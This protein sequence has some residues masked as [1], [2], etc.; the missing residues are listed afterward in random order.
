MINLENVNTWLVTGC[1]GFIGSNLIEY[2]LLQ[3]QKVV[4][5]DN[6]FAQTE[7]NLV[8]VKNI[9]GNKWRNFKFI[10]G[11]IR[12]KDDCMSAL[13]N[14]DY[15]LHNAAVGSVP[16]SMLYPEMYTSNNVLGFATLL[17][18]IKVNSV[19]RLVYASSS[20]V[21]GDTKTFPF[22]ENIIGNPLSPYAASKQINETYAK[23]YSE[24]Y[25]MEIV[26][27]RYFNVFGP[28][29]ATVG[30]YANVIPKWIDA[31]KIG[32]PITINGDG[33]T[34]RDFCHTDNIAQAN[35][36]AAT[37]PIADISQPVYNVACGT[38]TS[39][40]SLYHTLQILAEDNFKHAKNSSLHHINPRPGDMTHTCANI[41]NTSTDLGYTVQTTLEEGLA[42]LFTMAA[43]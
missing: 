35:L 17:D 42:Q 28:R 9:V 43:R 21:Y 29:A 30:A 20:S 6:F 18:A 37:A 25:N 34:S 27:L 4:G 32:A 5:L 10:R 14:I 12:S 38:H 31:F 7:S 26:G 15:V 41:T 36:L 40:N 19:K 22:V 13:K 11:D 8:S 3:N 2:L 24:C 33:S 1:A 23:V 16:R 39:L